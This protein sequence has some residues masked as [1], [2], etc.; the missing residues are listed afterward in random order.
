VKNQDK[1]EQVEQVAQEVAAKYREMS[2]GLGSTQKYSVSD[3]MMI[4]QEAKRQL[5]ESDKK[6]MEERFHELVGLSGDRGYAH[7]KL[8]RDFPG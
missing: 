1:V 2:Y 7:D 8:R 5:P 4:V 6:R 3:F